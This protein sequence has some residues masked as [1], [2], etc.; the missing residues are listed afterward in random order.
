MSTEAEEPLDLRA[1]IEAAI[2]ETQPEKV[3]AEPVETEKVEAEPVEA[4]KVEAETKTE[5]EAEPETETKAE[6]ETKPVSKPPASWRAGAKERWT[7]LPE[8]VREEVSRRERESAIAI[9]QNAEGRKFVEAFHQAIDPYRS[10]MAA[11]GVRDPLVAVQNLMQVSAGLRLGTPS[12]KAN[13]VAQII[14]TYGV[15]LQTLDSILSGQLDPK[16]VQEDEFERK[17]RE[18]LAPYEQFMQQQQAQRQQMESQYQARA[19][20]TVEQFAATNEFVDDPEVSNTMADLL[21]VAARR[22]REMSIQEAYD[23]A[24]QMVP[25]IAKIVNQR[26][27]AQSASA[28]AVERQKQAASSIKGAPSG[29]GA[30]VNT[31]D[32]RSTLEAAFEGKI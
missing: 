26:K 1:S 30:P 3:E 25:D 15:D 11:E 29:G 14:D 8:D 27:A 13:I 17:L 7:S 24:V 18:R 21:E 4:E 32:L 9:Q 31:K 10:V 16:R 19:A 6:P 5:A 2:D 23:R 28:A 20:Q 12:Q 22:G